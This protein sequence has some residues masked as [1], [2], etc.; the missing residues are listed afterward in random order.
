[1]D[2][3]I[4]KTIGFQHMRKKCPNFLDWLENLEWFAKENPHI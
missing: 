3:T 4:S 2:K 1:M